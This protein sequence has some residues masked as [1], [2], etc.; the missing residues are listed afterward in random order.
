MKQVRILLYS[1]M[2]ILAILIITSVCRAEEVVDL[3]EVETVQPELPQI[4]DLSTEVY[5][6]FIKKRT[7]ELKIVQGRRR[8][9]E[10]AADN[11]NAE[12]YNKQGRIDEINQLFKILKKAGYWIINSKK[13][14][15]IK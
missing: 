2:I 3:V 15:Q 12:E 4:K 14:G 1:G 9:M 13:A 11:L 5:S 6:K 10:E 7:K 8:L